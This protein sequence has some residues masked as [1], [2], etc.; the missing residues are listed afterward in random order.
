VKNVYE[1]VDHTTHETYWTLGIFATLL[2]ALTALDKIADPDDLP[3]ARD[4]DDDFCR[5]EI[6]ERPLGWND[7]PGKLV[8]VREWEHV[9]DDEADEFIWRRL[10]DSPPATAIKRKE[11]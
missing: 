9:L 3:D 5:V 10:P 6:R 7:G 8:H 1:V 4:K 2:D 11:P